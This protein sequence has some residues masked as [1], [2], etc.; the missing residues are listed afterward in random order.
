M[1]PQAICKH[2]RGKEDW[3]TDP[4]K[5]KPVTLSPGVNPTILIFLVFSRYLVRLLVTKKKKL[6][7]PKMAQFNDK[8][9]KIM[10]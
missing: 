4:P 5:P 2:Q 7:Y 8:N 6:I 10:D 9:G 1:T 3:H